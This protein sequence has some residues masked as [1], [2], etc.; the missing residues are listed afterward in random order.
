MNSKIIAI[1]F[2]GTCVTHEY[3]AV[4][5]DIGAASVIRELARRGNR[6]ILFTMRSGQHLQEA[7]KWFTAHGIELFGVNENPEQHTW[8]KS[9]KPYAHIYIDDA[10][11]GIPLIYPEGQRPYVDWSKVA[12]L[13]GVKQE[14]TTRDCRWVG[15][16]QTQQCKLHQ[17]HVDAIHEWAERAKSAEAK[18]T[19]IMNQE[20]CGWLS[21][22]DRFYKTRAMAVTN[23][24]Q[25]ITPVFFLPTILTLGPVKDPDDSDWNQ[26]HAGSIE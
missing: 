1:D 12:E 7:V 15:D 14:A 24:E 11:L 26:V 16:K 17:A 13:L 6:I 19:A 21:P 9:P 4:G 20:P 18:L 3:P 10:A 23:F 8:T 5:Q 25:L 2:D 22:V